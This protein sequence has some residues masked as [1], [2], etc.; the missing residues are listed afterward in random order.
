MD[1]LV[2]NNLAQ[3][4]ERLNNLTAQLLMAQRESND[5]ARRTLSA[6]KGLSTNLFA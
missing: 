3:G 5:L 1:S 4:V 6:T 2:N